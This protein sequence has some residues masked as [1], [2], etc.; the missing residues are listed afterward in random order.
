MNILHISPSIQPEFGGPSH[1]VPALCSALARAGQK[2]TLLTTNWSRTGSPSAAPVPA[3]DF[4]I[5]VVSSKPFLLRP[6]LPASSELA[7]EAVRLA[8]GH[9]VVHVHTLWNPATSGVLRALRRQRIPYF[10]TPHGMLDPLVLRRNPAIKL[11]W[12]SLIERDNVEQAHLLHFTS[13]DEAQK[14]GSL[15]WKLPDS[16]VA[17]NPIDCDYWKTLPGP[18]LFQNAFPAIQSG[19]VIMFV[20]RIDWVKNLDALISS[21]A[22]LRK[23]GLDCSLALVGP[24]LDRHG[25]TL[26]SQAE[27]A[28]IS[29]HVHFTGLL[30]GDLLRSALARAAVVALV[31]K[32]EN[33]GLAAAEALAAGV[34]VVLSPG[35][36]IGA[37]LQGFRFAQVA[38]PT[39]E[40]LAAAIRMLLDHPP[41]DSAREEIRSMAVSLW[42]GDASTRPLLEAYSRLAERPIPT[43]S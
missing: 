21:L 20:G 37:S 33:F 15:G 12:A 43:N 22:V 13:Q 4:S 34:P 10:L 25:A 31:S 5:R 40:S 29:R 32:K 2:V 42:G 8:A 17:P 19:P 36:A 24:D 1:S 27:E 18:E 7:Q 6:T 16:M 14:A 28:G 39:A 35:V 30:A 26:R 3:H 11:A 41:D 9:D 23:E 38:S